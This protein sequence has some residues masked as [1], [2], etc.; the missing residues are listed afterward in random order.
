MDKTFSRT[1]FPL[2]QREGQSKRER[3]EEGKPVEKVRE[4]LTLLIFFLSF[5]YKNS[6][7]IQS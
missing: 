6:T 5:L 2:D 7:C 4:F 3:E 1:G